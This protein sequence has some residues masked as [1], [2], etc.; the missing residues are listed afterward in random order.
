[1]GRGLDL[2]AGGWDIA[3]VALLQSGPF[4][5]PQFSGGDPS[6][7]GANVRGFTSTTRPDQTGDGNLGSPAVDRYFDRSAKFRCCG[8]GKKCTPHAKMFG[9]AD[10]E[11]PRAL[12]EELLGQ[13]G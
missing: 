2:L 3:G 12:A 11:L 10:R 8:T 1:M 13:R 9:Q 4:L 5:T 6:G 7:T